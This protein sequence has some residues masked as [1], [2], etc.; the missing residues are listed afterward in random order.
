MT[1]A[2]DNTTY[3]LPSLSELAYYACS[4]NHQKWYDEL[5]GASVHLQVCCESIIKII[6]LN[7]YRFQ[8]HG[9]RKFMFAKVNQ[10]NRLINNICE[11]AAFHG[12]IN[13][14][15]LSNS[16]VKDPSCVRYALEVK[17]R[18][19]LDTANTTSSFPDDVIP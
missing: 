2:D 19:R 16:D 7:S 4:S 8:P 17:N 6:K 13:Y 3:A 11:M 15:Y 1:A 18:L 12:H 10:G 9:H 5:P 14:G